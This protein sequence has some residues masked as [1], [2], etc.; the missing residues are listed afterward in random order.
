MKAPGRREVTQGVLLRTYGVVF[1][2][3]IALLVGL[4]VAIYDKVFVDV[5][6]VT[7]ETN[8]VGNQLAP[9]ADV[10]L[11]GMIVGEVRKVS[12][13]RTRASVDLALTPSTVGLIPSNVTARLL[14][15]TLFGEKFV[16]LQ[17]PSQPS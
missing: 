2:V 14:P 1:L 6:H 10:K 3:V 16:D 7:L 8:R 13:D 12:S 4:T 5:V 17:I 9:P 11:R 15:K